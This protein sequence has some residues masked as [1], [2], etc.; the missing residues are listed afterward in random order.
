VLGVP[1]YSSPAVTAGE[2]WLIPRD[3]VFIVLRTDPEVIADTSAYFSSDRTAVRAVL[4]VSPA[5]PHEAAIVRVVTD[6]GS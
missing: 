3:K 6:G 2:M 4:R 1:L 5:Y